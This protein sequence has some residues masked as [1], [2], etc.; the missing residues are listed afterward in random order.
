MRTAKTL[1]RLGG[2]FARRTLTLLV[3]TCRGSFIIR[4]LVDKFYK[5]WF[6]TLMCQYIPQALEVKPKPSIMDKIKCLICSNV[7]S[8]KRL[9]DL[10]DF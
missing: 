5:A 7:V 6:C 2:V 1:I 10:L 4:G 9:L 3:L 8:M